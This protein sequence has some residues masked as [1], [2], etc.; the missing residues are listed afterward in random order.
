MI[1][2]IGI[3]NFRSIIDNKI[4]FE[5]LTVIIGANGAGKSN[6]V[7][8]VELIGE[9][10]NTSIG[11]AISAQGGRNGI[12]P[13]LFGNT[14]IDKAPSKIEVKFKMPSYD[15]EYDEIPMLV[16]HSIEFSFTRQSKLI[17]N[18]ESIEFTSVLHVGEMLLKDRRKPDENVRED[19]KFTDNSVFSITKGGGGAI[20]VDLPDMKSSYDRGCMLTWLGFPSD[21]SQKFDT[22]KKIKDLLTSIAP[23]VSNNNY[24]LG[25]SFLDGRY[26]SLLKWSREFN[27]YTSFVSNIRRYD[28]LLNELR[29]EQPI[30]GPNRL[31]KIGSNL[32][33]TV[34]GLSLNEVA[35]RRIMHSL[36]EIAPHIKSLKTGELRTGSQFI[37]FIEV[38]SNKTVE[39]WHS[40]DGTLRALAILL[41]VETASIG[42]T[43][44]IEEPE[45]NLHPWAVVYL[46]DHIRKVVENNG[47]QVLVTTHSEH[48]LKSVESKEVRIATRSPTLGTTFKSIVDLV[49]DV[50]I[51][52]GDVG[53]L[54]ADGLLGGVP[55]HAL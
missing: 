34:T 33:Q 16:K 49:G 8:A 44:I 28:L 50:D 36:I 29:K 12:E 37:E 54:W 25:K 40:S 5:P 10:P 19:Y 3:N 22:K 43:I 9:I 17:I 31:D 52:K 46:M 39:S 51:E 38:N 11:Q 6:L 23:K 41:A 13:V 18:N 53:K 47:I 42:S 4:T 24:N 45:Q 26:E 32:P 30:G 55:N 48:V 35:M 1:E 2:E 15:T 27:G 21:W 14:D 7:K 20:K